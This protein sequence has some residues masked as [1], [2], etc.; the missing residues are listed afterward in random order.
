MPLSCGPSGQQGADKARN[1]DPEDEGRNWKSRVMGNRNNE[2][3][4]LQRKGE[5]NTKST[6]EMQPSPG[7]CFPGPD[8]AVSD[9]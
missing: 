3:R 7:L 4:W 9:S 1:P 6:E 8:L 2:L 5:E